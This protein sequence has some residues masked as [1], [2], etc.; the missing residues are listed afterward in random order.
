MGQ[1]D[2]LIELLEIEKASSR[3]MTDDDRRE[4]IADFL[5]DNGVVILPAK[6]GEP[7]YRISQKFMTK[8]RYIEKTNISRIAID[9]RGIVVFCA[10]QPT[11]KCIY[12]KNVFLSRED[13]EK[14]LREYQR[15][16][17]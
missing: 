15:G 11:V 7:V 2:E 3:Y 10:C 13:A 8:M 14:A 6:I 5:L 4:M 9:A 12:G 17:I 16:C 1:R